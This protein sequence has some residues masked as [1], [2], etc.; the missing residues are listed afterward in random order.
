MVIGTVITAGWF[1][2]DGGLHGR[3]NSRERMNATFSKAAI[4]LSIS[5]SLSLPICNRVGRLQ[6]SQAATKRFADDQP[7]P[8]KIEKTIRLC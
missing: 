5:A 2:Q 7:V 6:E 3:P 4:V 1:N 8:L